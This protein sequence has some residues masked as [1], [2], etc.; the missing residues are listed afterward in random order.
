M[1]MLWNQNCI[2]MAEGTE[3]GLQVGF[4]LGPDCHACVLSCLFPHPRFPFQQ[5]AAS[6]NPRVYLASVIWEHNGVICGGRNVLTGPKLLSNTPN[7][8][9]LPAGLQRELS[10]WKVY[11]SVSE[12]FW[13]LGCSW[14]VLRAEEISWERKGMP[15]H[16]AQQGAAGFSRKSHMQSNYLS[17]SSIFYLSSQA[18][19]PKHLG[20]TFQVADRM[21]RTQAPLASYFLAISFPGKMRCCWLAAI[22]TSLHSVSGP[23]ISSCLQMLSFVTFKPMLSI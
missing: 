15:C 19:F 3:A 10:L 21:L 20:S 4:R 22:S 9:F 7:I 16:V 13:F 8:N 18:S 23:M 1:H 17:A 11:L 5:K 6:C 14:C 12:A 2:F